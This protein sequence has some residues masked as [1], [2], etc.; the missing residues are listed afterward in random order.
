M[1]PRRRGAPS[2]SRQRAVPAR[3]RVTVRRDASLPRQATLAA[4]LRQSREALGKLEGELEALLVMLRDPAARA[5]ASAAD[6]LRGAV[7]A[8][9]FALAGLSNR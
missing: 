4:A 5:D 6:R 2:G 9:G 3:S 7:R 1:R 8:A